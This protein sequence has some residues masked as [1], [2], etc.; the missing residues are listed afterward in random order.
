M[1]VRCDREGGLLVAHAWIVNEGEYPVLVCE[2]V[3][4]EIRYDVE[5]S[6]KARSVFGV[7]GG[8]QIIDFMPRYVVLPPLR[9]NRNGEVMHPCDCEVLFLKPRNV[10]PTDLGPGTIAKSD[11]LRVKIRAI[12]TV[13]FLDPKALRSNAFETKR[14]DLDAEAVVSLQKD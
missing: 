9:R 14:V 12:A 10:A 4:L 3:G 8:T 2:N 13:T 11:A 1:R 7:D 5:F 6:A